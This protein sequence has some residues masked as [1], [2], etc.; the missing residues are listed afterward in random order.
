MSLCLHCSC[1]TGT[2]LSGQCITCVNSCARQAFYTFEFLQAN[3]LFGKL[4]GE[5]ASA[6]Y[7]YGTLAIAVLGAASWVVY[8]WRFEGFAG[9]LSPVELYAALHDESNIVLVDIR[10]EEE[11]RKEGVL[12]LTR[13]ARGKGVLLPLTQVRASTYLMRVARHR[14]MCLCAYLS[15]IQTYLVTAS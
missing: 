3:N 12:A 11:A 9:S 5:L 2:S 15:D 6:P 13:S 7:A 10:S 8:K 14:S 4:Y 1:S